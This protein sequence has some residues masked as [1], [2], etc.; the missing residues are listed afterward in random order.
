METVP[1]LTFRRASADDLAEVCALWSG[2]TPEQHR[3]WLAQR[4]RWIAL[5]YCA[6]ELVAGGELARCGHAVEIANVMVNPAWRGRG[7]GRALIMHLCAVARDLR[8][9]AV[10]LTVEPENAPALRLY[11][12]CGF[13]TIRT[14]TVDSSHHLLIMEKRL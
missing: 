3:A 1:T 7:I 14:L 10:Q 11:T 4:W 13:E 12:A 5:G 9:H 8:V 6:D 2:Q